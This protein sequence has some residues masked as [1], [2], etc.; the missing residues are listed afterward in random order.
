MR[1]SI[2]F[3]T[4]YFANPSYIGGNDSDVQFHFLKYSATV[5]TVTMKRY[6]VGLIP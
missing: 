1:L 3:F 4:V 6:T 5:D 2:F